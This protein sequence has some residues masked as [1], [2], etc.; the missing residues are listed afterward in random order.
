MHLSNTTWHHQNVTHPAALCCLANDCL[1]TLRAQWAAAS[2]RWLN[3]SG[4]IRFSACTLVEWLS[5]VLHIAFCGFAFF[6]CACEA[7]REKLNAFFRRL[8]TLTLGVNWFL[9]QKFCVNAVD[10]RE[11]AFCWCLLILF[12]VICCFAL[13]AKLFTRV[14]IDFGIL[15]RL[16]GFYNW[17]V[18]KFWLSYL[19]GILLVLIDAKVRALS[20]HWWYICKY[21]FTKKQNSFT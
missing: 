2:R 4:G 17:Q 11:V 3:D 7:F 12:V 15:A 10:W 5:N 1:G 8:P 14:N 19:I 6:W 20:C 13:L 21:S 18:A 16:F 9:C